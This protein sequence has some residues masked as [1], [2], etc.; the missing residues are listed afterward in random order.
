MS[1]LDFLADVN[2]ILKIELEKMGHN[3][4]KSNTKD[5]LSLLFNLQKKTI[6]IKKRTVR[7]SKELKEKE[8]EEPFNSYLNQINSKFENGDDI[9]PHMSKWSVDPLKYDL[10]LYDWGIH[11]LHLEIKFDDKGFI[12]RSDYILFFILKEND[13][14]FLDVTKHKLEDGTQFS[15]QHLVTIVKRNWPFL[16]QRI[17]GI[18]GEDISDKKYSELRRYGSMSLINVD[19]EVFAPMGGGYSTAKTSV[20]NTI[21]SHQIIDS[22]RKKEKEMKHKRNNLEE[23]TND[24]RITPMKLDYKLILENKSFYIVEENTGIKLIEIEG[25]FETIFGHLI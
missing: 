23:I 12:K 20:S 15:Q 24:L 7:I 4:V 11:H 25:L 2:K 10:L 14:Y 16:L 5:F 6:S 21:K 8:I 3:S 17:N 1:S 19:G 22:L 13:V 9:N 18:N